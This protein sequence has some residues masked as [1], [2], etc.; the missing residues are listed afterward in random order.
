MKKNSFLEGAFI[1]T[2][3]I[4]ITKFIGIIYVI[5]FYNI[6]GS[7]G[8]ALYGYAY[9]IYNVFLIISC[10]GIPL[11][12]SKITSEYNA[13][14]KEPEKHYLYHVAKKIIFAFSLV[15]FLLCFV[16][17]KYIAILIIG[18]MTGG[19]TVEDIAFVIRAVSFALLIVPLLSTNRGYLQGH[20]Y[21]K[22]SSISQVIEQIVRVAIVLLGSFLAIDVFNLSLKTGVGIAVFAA[23]IGAISAYFYLLKKMKIFKPELKDD[24]IELEKEKRKEIVKKLVFYSVP[25]IVINI[26]NS[27]YNSIDMILMMRGLHMIGYETTDIETISGI[28]TTW[29]NKLNTIITSFASGVAISLMPSM[30]SSKAIK[31]NKGVNDKINKTLQI[32]LYVVLPLALFMSIFANTIWTIFYGESLYG[33][34]IFKYSIIVA[35]IDALY[36]MISNALQGL[37]KTKLIYISVILGLLINASLDIPLILLFNKLGIYP[38]YGAITATLIGYTISLIIPFTNLHKN[39][40]IKYNETLKKLPKI[41]ISYLVLIIIAILINKLI[42]GITNKLLLIILLGITGLI[43]LVIYLYLNRKELNDIISIDRIKKKFKKGE[44]NE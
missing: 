39:D 2:A 5:P 27:L 41:F 42:I 30:A 25:F 35:A 40:G 36:I 44:T 24:Y 8:G 7:Q 16:F 3:A 18:D 15:S 19:N 37:N 29:G 43:L 11:A 13:L 28:F 23:S 38:Y 33:P 1:A 21:I 26:A 20:S 4:F 12:I 17:A 22:P 34:I 9:N 14:K 32:F 31:D 10:S 6:V